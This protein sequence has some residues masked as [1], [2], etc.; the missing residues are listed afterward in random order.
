VIILKHS[1][2]IENILKKV[3]F[4]EHKKSDLKTLLA[5]TPTVAGMN[6]G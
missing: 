3:I 4:Y 5:G 1:L 6:L 2:K